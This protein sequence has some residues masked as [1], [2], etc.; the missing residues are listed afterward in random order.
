MDEKGREEWRKTNNRRIFEANA[1]HDPKTNKYKT[2]PPR[3]QAAT[4]TTQFLAHWDKGCF[5]DP[6]PFE[7]MYI[8]I[9]VGTINGL[10]EYVCGV[11]RK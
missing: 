9:N 3:E 6:L 5:Q 1:V 2:I 4:A 8:K 10:S 11:H 7:E